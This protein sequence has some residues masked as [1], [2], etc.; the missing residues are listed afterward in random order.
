MKII[1]Y[2]ANINNYDYFY[3]PD[4]IDK[5]VEYVLFTDNNYFKSNIWK[6]INIS[7]LGIDHLDYRRKARYLK[8]NS[9]IVLPNHNVSIWIDHC[10][11][12]KINDANKMLND[13]CFENKNAMIYNHSWRN[14]IY[15]EAKECIS[16]KL[17]SKEVIEK[18]MREYKKKSFPQN[19]GLFETGFMI[20]RYNQDTI[21]FNN[22]WWQEILNGSGRD[23]LSQNYAAW[24]TKYKVHPINIGKSQYDSP[25]IDKKN[26]HNKIIQFK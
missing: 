16:K 7:N 3:H 8:I 5:N 15:E 14:C 22:L 21:N 19:N 20:R 12:S 2:S 10:F 18:Q 1:I 13:L 11:K 17:D 9:H 6:V 23:Q 24:I 25:F 26:K 4:I